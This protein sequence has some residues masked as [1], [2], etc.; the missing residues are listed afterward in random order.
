MV[1]RPDVVLHENNRL[2]LHS[3]FSASAMIPKALATGEYYLKLIKRD[4]K[5]M[6]TYLPGVH[7]KVI[8]SASP[9]RHSIKKISKEIHK[10][11]IN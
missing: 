11:E 9:E 7:V 10:K 6:Q 8:A 5:Q 4:K 3:G 1:P 2:L